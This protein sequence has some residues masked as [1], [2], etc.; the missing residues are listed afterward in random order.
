MHTKRSLPRRAA[1]VTAL[2]LVLLFGLGAC[3]ND[4]S[5]ESTAEVEGETGVTE[6]EPL[7]IDEA[8]TKFI[9]DRFNGR[10]TDACNMIDPAYSAAAFPEGCAIGLAEWNDGFEDL[11]ATS[12]VRVD[13]EPTSDVAEVSSSEIYYTDEDGEEN[14]A[15]FSLTFQNVAGT[16]FVADGP[17]EE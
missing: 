3:G 8:G 6:A 14:T 4:D 11:Y 1:S 15:S 9:Q 5:A 13:E 17:W 16:W 7:S 10:I 12:E 2:P